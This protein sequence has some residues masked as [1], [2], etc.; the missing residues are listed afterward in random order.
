MAG[1]AVDIAVGRHHRG[2]APDPDGRLERQQLLVAELARA[3]V[4]RCLVEPALGQ[5]VTDHVLA[6]GDD[7]VG[8]VVPLEAAN[9]R[10][11]EHHGEVRVLPVR[12]FDPTPAGV[13]RDVEDRRQGDPP[14]GRQHPP[15]ERVGH[16]QDQLRVEGGG[17]SDRL[18]ERWRIP[19]E[20]PMERLLVEEGRDPQPRLLEQVPLDLVAGPSH[21]G[22]IQVGGAGDPGD[23]AE[24]VLEEAVRLVGVQADR[25]VD[26]LERPRRP[27]LGELLVERHPPEE[28]GDARV[29]RQ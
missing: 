4:D 14:A 24:A 17:R 29:D 20:Q 21:V 12:L 16:G 6:R 7:A 11:A 2:Q 15:S 26:E 3:D 25:C 28:V 5:A 1:H 10:Q 9:V 13:A 18:L 8:D 27:E 19:G 22:G 23:V